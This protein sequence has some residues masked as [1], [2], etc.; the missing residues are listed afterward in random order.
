MHVDFTP[1]VSLPD[2][3]FALTTLASDIRNR[4]QGKPKDLLLDVDCLVTASGIVLTAGGQLAG[5]HEEMKAVAV[6]T[7]PEEQAKA[8]EG[9]AAALKGPGVKAFD[10]STII[11]IIKLLLDQFFPKS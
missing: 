4:A 3:T 9:A 11:A 5:G 10:W 7:D 8:L 1:V 6:P 2:A